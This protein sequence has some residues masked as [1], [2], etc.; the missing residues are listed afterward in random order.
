[1]TAFARATRRDS[2]SARY[3]AAFG[4]NDYH[5]LISP[6]RNVILNLIATFYKVGLCLPYLMQLTE[7]KLYRLYV[8]TMSLKFIARYL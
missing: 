1:M 8:S 7:V 2:A 3:S 4:A 6:P 5:C